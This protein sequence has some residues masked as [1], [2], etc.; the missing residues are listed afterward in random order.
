MCHTR[1]PPEASLHTL[2]IAASGCGGLQRGD[3]DFFPAAPLSH[4]G[5]GR[6][7]MALC[8]VVQ[9]KTGGLGSFTVRG[10]PPESSLQA[11]LDPRKFVTL[12]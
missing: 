12:T 7:K 10:S 3:K 6:P 8:A 4:Y 1:K 9:R 5:I 2:T 11:D